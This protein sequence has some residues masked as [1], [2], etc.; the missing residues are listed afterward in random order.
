[1]KHSNIEKRKGAFIRIKIQA[2]KSEIQFE[3]ENSIPQETIQ[4]DE[5]GGIGLENV[6]RRL[7]ILY[8]QEHDLKIDDNGTNFKVLLKIKVNGKA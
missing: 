1:M 8:P 4:K 6:K 5:V 3:M 7:E 2:T